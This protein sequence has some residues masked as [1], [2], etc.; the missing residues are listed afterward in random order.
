MIRS[1]DA[2]PT[3]VRSQWGAAAWMTIGFAPI[4]LM[5]GMGAVVKMGEA[6]QTNEADD[7]LQAE[8]FGLVTLA[9]LVFY[10]ISMRMAYKGRI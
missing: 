6:M 1:I 3:E 9:V 10:G 4:L 8:A 7:L 5:F 2:L